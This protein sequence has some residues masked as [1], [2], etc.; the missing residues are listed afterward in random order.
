MPQVPRQCPL[1]MAACLS[2]ES[3]LPW[4][5]RQERST[6]RRELCMWWRADTAQCAAVAPHKTTTS[7][8]D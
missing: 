2:C 8:D 6:C 7:R 5:E 3:P 4:A 1:L